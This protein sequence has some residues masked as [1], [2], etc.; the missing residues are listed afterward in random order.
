MRLAQIVF[1]LLGVAQ[2]A[3]EDIEVLAYVEIGFLIIHPLWPLQEL[4]EGEV[5][6]LEHD[7]LRFEVTVD[8]T[9]G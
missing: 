5:F 2:V 9:V 4:L 7:V 1:T 6:Q 8:D 3:D